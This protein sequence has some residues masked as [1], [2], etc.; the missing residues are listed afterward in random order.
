MEELDEKASA[1]L[2]QKHQLGLAQSK[3]TELDVAIDQVEAYELENSN[4]IEELKKELDDLGVTFDENNPLSDLDEADRLLIELELEMQEVVDQPKLNRV[5]MLNFNQIL[6]DEMSWDEYISSVKEYS[7]KNSLT[8]ANPFDGLLTRS[9]EADLRNRIQNEFTHKAP[10]CDKIDY[11]IASTSGLICG[12]IDVVFV[13]APGESPLG[14]AVDEFANKS[15][16]KFANLLGWDAEKAGLKGSNTTASAIGFLEGKFKVNY[17]QA[18]TA[19][20]DG[21]VPNLSLKNHHLK[22]LGHSP[23]LIGLFFSV[24]NQFTSTSTFISNGQ[25]IT[26]DT[27]TN[28]LKGNN[29]VAKVFC[30]IANWF[31]HIMSDWTGSSGTVGQG[32]RGMGVPI[33]F[34]NL[35]LGL[36][37][38]EFGENKQSIA[39]VATKVFE[40]GY[41]ARHGLTMAIPVVLN[42]LIIRFCW[43]IRA[44]FFDSKDWKD[45]IPSESNPELRRMLFVGQGALC[46]VDGVDAVIRGGGEIVTTLLRTNLIA[47]A[48]FA[49]LSLKELNAWAMQGKIDHVL[50]DK[51]LDQEFEKILS[52]SYSR[53]R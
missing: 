25:L 41:D 22:S 33:P 16:E 42:E 30:G 17:D 15:T 44:R 12:I 23:D 49:H 29:F 37:V 8:S 38:G 7:D 26:V 1:S 48:R 31:G 52:T 28:E 43:V 19:A 53:T 34:Y 24:L 40:K 32:G 47:W 9:Q 6:D 13:G 45:C 5:E 46:L 2:V 3:T 11:A 35:L 4:L 51:Y 10:N 21:A 20:V 14:N 18:T 27:E 50:I 36:N 39:T